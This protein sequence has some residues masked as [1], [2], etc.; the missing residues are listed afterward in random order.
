MNLRQ[1]CSEIAAA[2][3]CSGNKSLSSTAGLPRARGLLVLA[4]PLA[5][6]APCVVLPRGPAAERQLLIGELIWLRAL[7]EQQRVVQIL[8]V[9]A[10]GGHVE[11]PVRVSQCPQP[12]RGIGTVG[13]AGAGA[14][15]RL[16]G[17]SMV[18][19][20]RPSERQAAPSPLSVSSPC[21]NSGR[22]G[23]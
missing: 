14:P 23:Q 10:R 4:L 22:A 15:A 2:L 20:Q 16:Q 21:G 18:R 1:L 17:A 8:P 7:A 3:L 5:I 6:A 9:G 13:R 19:G 12:R 11:L